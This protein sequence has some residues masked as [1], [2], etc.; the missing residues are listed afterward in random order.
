MI[1][2]EK[3]F[4]DLVTALQTIAYATGQYTN[5]TTVNNIESISLSLFSINET[6]ERIADAMENKQMS[7]LEKF[8]GTDMTA[9]VQASLD[10]K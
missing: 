10:C 4:S 1:S 7:M 6:L 3:T 2:T 9:A 5:E 8:P